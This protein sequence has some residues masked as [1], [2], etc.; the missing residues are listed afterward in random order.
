MP[1]VLNTSNQ[2]KHFSALLDQLSSL[3]CN[4]TDPKV[5]FN[6]CLTLTLLAKGDH[7]RSSEV[8]V[9]LKRDSASICEQLFGLLREKNSI[10]DFTKIVDVELSISLSLRRLSLLS[11]RWSLSSL[12]VDGPNT[13]EKLCS[14]VSASVALDLSQRKLVSDEEDE[15]S[16]ELVPEIWETAPEELHEQVKDSI[17]AGLSF[18]L[19]TTAWSLKE[20]LDRTGPDREDTKS[21]VQMRDRLVKLTSLCFE[22]YI[23]DN[24]TYERHHRYF[25]RTIQVHASQIAG[26]L[27]T[28]FHKEW[29]NSSDVV[30]QSCALTDDSHLIGGCVRFLRSQ[31][32]KVRSLVRLWDFLLAP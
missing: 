28:L 24:D 29:S 18:L 22:M 4:A 20:Q 9:V 12:L 19:N 32:E 2:K 3:F 11:K 14:A 21:T 1:S 17:V 16:E 8:L 25:S 30:L 23:E 13:V 15:D 6:C 7:T 5:L 27:R 26:D 31:E 10:D